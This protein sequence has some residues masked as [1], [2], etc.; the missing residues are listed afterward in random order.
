MPGNEWEMEASLNKQFRSWFLRGRWRKR[1]LPVQQLLKNICAIISYREVTVVSNIRQCF[2][3][4]LLIFVNIFLKFLTDFVNFLPFQVLCLIGEG[5]DEESDV[6][7]GCVVNV[8][9]KGNKLSV[10]IG[11]YKRDEVVLKIG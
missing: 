2:C 11:D 5:F 7:N 9:G 10:W 8:R 6:V 3:G 4:C 1:G